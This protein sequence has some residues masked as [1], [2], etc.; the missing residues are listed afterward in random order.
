MKVKRGNDEMEVRNETQA[1]AFLQSGWEIVEDGV[2]ATEEPVNVQDN[3]SSV[4]T[5]NE[6]QTPNIKRGRPAKTE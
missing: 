2:S 1:S 5:V 4:K 3:N 6:N